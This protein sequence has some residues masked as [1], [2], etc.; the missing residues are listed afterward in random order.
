MLFITLEK[1]QSKHYN[2]YPLSINYI[3][4]KFKMLTPN[5]TTTLFIIPAPKNGGPKDP[6]SPSAGVHQFVH[7]PTP[8]SLRVE[9]VGL[10]IPEP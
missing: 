1:C 5:L 2:N 3:F 7:G 6:H 9:T 10:P 8:H 4:L